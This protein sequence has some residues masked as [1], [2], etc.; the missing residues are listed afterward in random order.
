MITEGIDLRASR[1]GLLGCRTARSAQS[2]IY[3]G[4][5]R[6]H[7]KSILLTT[8]RSLVTLEM[9]EILEGSA[10]AEIRGT[11]LVAPR[12]SVWHYPFTSN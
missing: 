4:V 9:S 3:S 12:R 10:A 6:A 2:R 1:C 11:I 8:P 7:G 5:P